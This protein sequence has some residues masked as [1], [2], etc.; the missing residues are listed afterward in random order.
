MHR[1][2]PTADTRGR[3]AHRSGWLR[4]LA[5]VGVLGVLVWRLG[6]GPFTTGLGRVG[7]LSLA[8]ASGVA[9]VTTVCCAW[10]WTLVA[11]ALGVALPLHSAVAAYYR[12][13]FLNLTL[14]GGVLGDVERAV[15]HGRAVGDSGRG[16][17]SVVWERFA[18]QAVLV[19]GA[20]SALV[21]MPSPVR[22]GARVA[23]LTVVA[24]GLLVLLGVRVLHRWPVPGRGLGHRPRWVRELKGADDELRTVVLARHTRSRIVLASVVAMCGHVATFL[25]AARTAGSEAALVTLLPLALVVLLAM[26]LPNVAGWGPREGVAAWAFGAGGLGAQQGV[27]TAVVYGVMVLAGALPGAILMLAAGLKRAQAVAHG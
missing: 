10:R 14:P 25:V 21:F 20:G 3:G 4:H 24:G 22:Q 5:A 16:L 15:R 19:A 1:R 12:S 18:G 23:G 6:T 8:T 27:T 9:V 2:R 11:R 26:G 7:A 17:R 13:Q